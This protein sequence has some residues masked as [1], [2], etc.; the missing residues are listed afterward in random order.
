MSLKRV[1]SDINVIIITQTIL[2]INFRMPIIVKILIPVRIIV[3]GINHRLTHL[4]S[5]SG[6]TMAKKRSKVT[7]NVARTDPSR[8]VSVNP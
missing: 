2:S 5:L 3:P 4:T 1:L 7:D 8:N 6:R